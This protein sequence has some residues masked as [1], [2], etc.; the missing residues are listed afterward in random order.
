MGPRNFGQSPGLIV[1]MASTLWLCVMLARSGACLVMHSVSGRATW[2]LRFLL[3]KHSTG[4]MGLP[5]TD[6]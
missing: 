4:Q 6:S 2:V 5:K 1:V 3:V